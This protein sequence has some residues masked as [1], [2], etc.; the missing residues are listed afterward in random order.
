M[1][2][3]ITSTHYIITVVALATFS[4]E[5]LFS[6]VP[7]ILFWR[8][9][10][11]WIFFFFFWERSNVNAEC[12]PNFKTNQ[13]LLS[14]YTHGR[15]DP[16]SFKNLQQ[17]LYGRFYLF[18]GFDLVHVCLAG[19]YGHMW[20]P[21]RRLHMGFGETSDTFTDCKLLLNHCPSSSAFSHLPQLDQCPCFTILALSHLLLGRLNN[22]FIQIK[23]QT[24][25]YTDVLV[26]YSPSTSNALLRPQKN[27]PNTQIE[28]PGSI[29]K[30]PLGGLIISPT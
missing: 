1:A 24:K 19:A 27:T 18:L 30:Q 28:E 16:L 6:I 21:M 25:T 13:F 20:T 8:G 29:A 5:N 23:E 10:N 2:H 11:P 7:T 17:G 3:S 12:I 26:L 14:P 15:Q 4:I 9:V 22:T